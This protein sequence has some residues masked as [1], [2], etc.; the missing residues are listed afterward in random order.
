VRVSVL[1][2]SKVEGVCDTWRR[3]SEQGSF[4]TS[5]LARAHVKSIDHGFEAGKVGKSSKGLFV[6]L[7]NSR[8]G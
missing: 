2:S 6:F 4:Y 5:L 3:R 1:D 8:E 7:V